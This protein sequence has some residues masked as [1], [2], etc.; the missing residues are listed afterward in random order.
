MGGIAQFAIA[1]AV[2]TGVLLHA[3]PS[4]VQRIAGKPHDMEGMQHR[5]RIKKHQPAAT[6]AR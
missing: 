1:A 4:L 6:A 5:H 3:L 2:P